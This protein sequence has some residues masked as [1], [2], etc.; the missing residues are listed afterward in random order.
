MENGF[1]TQKKYMERNLKDQVGNS[2][3]PQQITGPT[4]LDQL[5]EVLLARKSEASEQSYT[6]YLY[7]EGLDKI[8]KKVGEE[9]TEVV[10]AAKNQEAKALVGEVAD[11]LYHL[12][13]MLAQQNIAPSAIYEELYLRSKK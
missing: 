12:W 2:A 8:L 1:S 5:Y 4:I 3:N 13:V 11:L 9:A 10:I 6:A 7:R